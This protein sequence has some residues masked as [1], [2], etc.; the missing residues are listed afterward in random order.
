MGGGGGWGELVL[1]DVP[2]VDP[3]FLY[4]ADWKFFYR[5]VMGFLLCLLR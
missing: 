5:K 4:P 2:V 3:V 1:D